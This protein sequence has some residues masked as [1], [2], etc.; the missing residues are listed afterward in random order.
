[1]GL[2]LYAYCN[3]DNQPLPIDCGELPGTPFYI[4]IGKPG[5][6]LDHLKLAKGKKQDTINPR[7]TQHIRHLIDCNMLPHII[8]MKD[9][10]TLDE[11][12]RLEKSVIAEI[13][14][15]AVVKHVEKR[16]PLLNLH[17]GGGG[18]VGSKKPKSA[19]TRAKMSAAKM[20]IKLTPEQRARFVTCGANRVR[21]PEEN[22]RRG[23]SIAR[24]LQ[25][26]PPEEV[27]AQMEKR[28]S[29]GWISEEAK[30]IR[31]ER[32]ANGDLK[33]SAKTKKKIAKSVTEAMATEEVKQKMV[34]GAAR[35]WSDDAERKKVAERNSK[36]YQLTHRETGEVLII[37]NMQ[38]FCRD[39]SSHP[40][41][42]L[43]EYLVVRPF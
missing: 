6:Q 34:E 41:R 23:E 27:A 25:S 10:L 9:G 33:H 28:K 38:A 32:V 8:V 12:K 22:R 37:K 1:M 26:R 19:E 11:A 21:S 3:P 35:R 30:A 24:S 42:V 5:R 13:G 7:K 31:A 14:T 36:T 43:K 18:G 2:I 39:T 17:R 15:V 29:K 4:G 16:G 20:G 40:R